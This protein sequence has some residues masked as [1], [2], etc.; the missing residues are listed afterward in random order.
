MPTI[1]MVVAVERHGGIGIDNKLPW[2]I[3]DDLKHFR[4]VTMGDAVIMGRKT[5]ESLPHKLPGRLNIVLSTTLPAV[6]EEDFVVTGDV[7]SAIEAVK[8]RGYE[9]LHVIGGSDV[10]RLFEPFITEAYVT[11]IKET[12]PADT[13]LEGFEF[14]QWNKVNEIERGTHVFCTYLR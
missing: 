4:Q 11:H 6:S 3:P 13:F 14:E 5:F 10:Y 1:S 7:E 2:N 12:Y 9:T 8:A